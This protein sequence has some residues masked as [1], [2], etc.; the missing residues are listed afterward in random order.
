[1]PGQCYRLSMWFYLVNSSSTISLQLRDPLD[2]SVL[3][4]YTTPFLGTEDSWQQFSFD[5]T[6]PVSC[7]NGGQVRVYLAN[8]FSSFSGNDYYVDDISLETISCT[9]ASSIACPSGSLLALNRVMLTAATNSKGVSLSWMADDEAD[10]TAYRLQK[11][12]DGINFETIYTLNV[13]QDATAEAHTYTDATTVQAERSYY[14]IAAIKKSGA[15]VYSS[16]VSI[17]SLKPGNSVLV[18]PQP[19]RGTEPVY[20]KINEPL[21]ASLL[22]YNIAGVKLKTFKCYPGQILPVSGL[23]PGQY[24]LRTINKTGIGG[25]VTKLVVE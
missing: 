2:N 13:A 1:V 20:V 22:L 25:S 9:G 5:F 23:K 16:T 6:L 24:I 21:A 18:Y 3:G 14:R 8:A 11:S 12:T 10:A 17:A 4:S 19:A 15:I 7:T